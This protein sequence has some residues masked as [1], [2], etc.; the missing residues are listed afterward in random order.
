MASSSSTSRVRHKDD[1]VRAVGCQLHKVV[2]TEA[3]LDTLR[4]GVEREHRATVLKK[5]EQE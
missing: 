1:P 4:D 3:H 2:R 5:R